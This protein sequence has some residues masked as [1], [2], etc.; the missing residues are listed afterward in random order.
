[1]INLRGTTPQ[2]CDGTLS[3]FPLELEQLP[4]ITLNIKHSFWG[5]TSSKTRATVQHK[6][7][8]NENVHSLC[9]H[10]KNTNSHIISGWWFQ[11]L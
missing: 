3:T 1:M 4:S 6:Q 10:E 11:P 7:T 2:L 8:L 9:K 5:T